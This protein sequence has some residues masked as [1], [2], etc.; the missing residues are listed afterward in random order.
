MGYET[1]IIAGY[2]TF[3]L[4]IFAAWIGGYLDPLQ[5]QLQDVIL[6]KM[7]DN[8]AS[9]GLKGKPRNDA[10]IISVIVLILQF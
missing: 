1:T 9:Y 8:R 10:L 2:T 5:H 6:G 7:G 3:L 4:V